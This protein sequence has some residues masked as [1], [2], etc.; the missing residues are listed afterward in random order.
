MSESPFTKTEPQLNIGLL[1]YGTVG[2]TVAELLDER[3]CGIRI[4]HILRRPGHADG[5]LMTDSFEAVL[6]DPEVTCIV[7]AL[8][9]R[10]PALS[11]I[12]AALA[13]GKHVVTSNKAAVA[14]DLKGLA[15]LARANNVS[16]LFEASCG[17]GM[18]WVEMIKKTARFNEVSDVSGI[19]NGTCNYILT[20][21]EGEGRDFASV[22]AD[23]QAMGYAEA[24]PSFDIDG[25]DAAHKLSI[26]AS[27]A[28][29]TRLDF[30]SVETVGIR[31]VLSSDIDQARA[32]GFRVR[33]VGLAESG[34]GGLF[35]RVHPCLVPVAHPLAHVAGSMNAVVAEGNFVGR[36]FFEGRGAGEGPTA[37][38]VVAD[39][40]DIARGEFGPA[41]A[42][43]V[44]SL[45]AQRRADAGDRIGRAYLRFAVAD[46]PGVLAELTA[47]MR[48]ANVSIES[49]I[50]R[51]EAPGG[52]VLV[53]M[54]THEGPERNVAASLAALAGSAS[55]VGQPM[56]MPV[57]DV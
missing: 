9:G 27:L 3:D 17:G 40:I 29:G 15:E 38:A 44:E 55:L 11:Y 45:A 34:A 12:R 46:R 18:H 21:M 36:L 19:L 14:A 30:A 50:Q 51:G 7:E 39:L 24:D 32:L 13:A 26:L 57:L 1:G 47:A 49:M 25:I 5:P 54:T 37:S 35:Q 4:R 10:D 28:F 23:A 16:L 22:L 20:T 48:D 52:G 8:P 43:P 2:R 53:V 41:F 56:M 42:M 33:L 6:N 31:N